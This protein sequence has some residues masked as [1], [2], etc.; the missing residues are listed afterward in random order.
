[1]L[2]WRELERDA[3]GKAGVRFFDGMKKVRQNMIP[4]AMTGRSNIT[5]IPE[6]IE[7]RVEYYST[8]YSEREGI[9]ESAIIESAGYT[10]SAKTVDTRGW[11]IGP[12][13][14]LTA[15]KQL[16]T[17]ARAKATGVRTAVTR[18]VETGNVEE[19][20]K[21]EHPGAPDDE[22]LETGNYKLKSLFASKNGQ[23]LT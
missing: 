3:H 8:L 5:S 1:M 4:V 14:R 11:T 22:I 16:P 6:E 21:G 17:S 19:A 13:G 9:D 23:S 7:R 15:R 12:D 2:Q 18:D 20:K 10:K